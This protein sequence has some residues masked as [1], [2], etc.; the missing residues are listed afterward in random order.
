MEPDSVI[1]AA[2]E[3]E[4]AA[5]TAASASAVLSPPAAS[6]DEFPSAPSAAIAAVVCA[7]EVSPA[8]SAAI[9]AVVS[10]DAPVLPVETELQAAMDV[11]IAASV[12]PVIIILNFLLISFAFMIA[13]I[14]SCRQ[15]F[16]I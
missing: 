12:M 9:A 16:M 2:T 15:I 11:T 14:T 13:V 7:D 3:V 8:S 6:T 10:A 4:P 5:L 1:S